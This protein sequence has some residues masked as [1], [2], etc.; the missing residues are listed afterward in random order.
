[1]KILLRLGS[2]YKLFIQ[3]NP[4]PSSFI[5]IGL[6]YSGKTSTSPLPPVSSSLRPESPSASSQVS[7]FSFFDLLSSIR[8]LLL[9]RLKSLASPLSSIF[10]QIH[11]FCP[12]PR[13]RDRPVAFTHL[14]FQPLRLRL[15]HPF[16]PSPISNIDPPPLICWS[17]WE[18]RNKRTV[19]STVASLEKKMEWID[20]S[21]NEIENV[22]DSLSL[23]YLG[24][25][26]R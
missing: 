25:D 15:R 12:N 5:E 4:S 8:C 1:M 16:R 14:R 10:D 2:V 7:D 17:I 26:L 11:P 13:Q 21:A 20:E 3:S 22:I 23:R 9:L 6:D 24:S 18:D 19:H